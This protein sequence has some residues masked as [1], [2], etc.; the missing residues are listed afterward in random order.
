MKLNPE[1]FINENSN[2]ELFFESLKHPDDRFSLYRSDYEPFLEQLSGIVT[3][4]GIKFKLYYECNDQNVYG[5]VKYVEN[6]SPASGVPSIP[7]ISTGMEGPAVS[8]A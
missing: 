6:S 5:W 7:S 1:S 4:D 3:S 2:P 8:I